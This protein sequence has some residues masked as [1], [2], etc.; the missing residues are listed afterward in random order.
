MLLLL[1]KHSILKYTLQHG[2]GKDRT[3]S[4]CTSEIFCSLWGEVALCYALYQ[5]WTVVNLINAPPDG[6]AAQSK[7][8]VTI[9]S[10]ALREAS[11]PILKSLE[12]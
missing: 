6:S 9:S 1:R 3:L 2:G 10:C 11:W 12:T 8:E 7:M 4:P 5:P